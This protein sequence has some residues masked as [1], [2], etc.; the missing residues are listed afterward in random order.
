MKNVPQKLTQRDRLIRSSQILA[1][2]L[3]IYFKEMFGDRSGEFN[4]YGIR[5]LGFKC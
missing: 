5:I 3:Y 1:Q 2:T 4:G